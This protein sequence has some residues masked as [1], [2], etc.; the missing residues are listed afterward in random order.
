MATGWNEY[1]REVLYRLEDC[2]ARLSRVE[3]R[4]NK[5]EVQMG[6]MKVRAGFMGALAASIVILVQW[7]IK[8]A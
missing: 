7:V 2:Q 3:S 8:I 4:L 6:A 5:L 1:Q